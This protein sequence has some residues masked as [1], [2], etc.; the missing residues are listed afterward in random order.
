MKPV[1]WN[2]IYEAS[3]MELDLLS[4]L[5]GTGLMKPDLWNWIYE[6]RYK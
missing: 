2:W 6:A 4:Q 3:Y 5:Y 1:I